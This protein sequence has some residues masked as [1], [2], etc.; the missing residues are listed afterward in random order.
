MQA[1]EKALEKKNSEAKEK[2]SLRDQDVRKMNDV[3][4]K[5]N[6]KL[7]EDVASLKELLK[8]QKSV[9]GGKLLNQKSLDTAA[10]YLMR[11]SGAKGNKAE[12]SG[13][14]NDVYSYIAGGEEV[15]WDGIMEKAS[16]AADWIQEH[17]D[18]KQQLDPYGAEVLRELRGSRVSLDESQ[19][20]EAEYQFGSVNALRKQLFGTVTITDK[21]AV[22][23]DSKWAELSRMYPDVFDPNTS[24]ADMPGAL[25]DAIDSLKNMGVGEMWYDKEAA[26]QELLQQIYHAFVLPMEDFY[27]VWNYNTGNTDTEQSRSVNATVQNAFGT[28]ATGYIDQLLKDLNGGA[29]IDPTTGLIS[30]SMNLFKKGA[31]FA[32]ASVVIQQPSAIGR[33][34]AMIDMKYFAGPRVTKENYKD[35]LNQMKKYAPVAVI[36]EMGYF[37]T[38]MGKSTKDYILSREYEGV[39]EKAKAFFTDS[40]YRDEALSRG[41]ALADEVTWCCIWEAVKR[42]TRAKHPELSVR[43]ETFLQMAGERFTD[44][45][46]KTQVY[47]SI[48]S[49]SGNM[50]SKD[51]GMKMATAFMAEPT[52]SINMIMDA[53][54]K[55]KRNGAQGRRYCRK[56]IGAVAAAQVINSVLVSFV[57]AARDDDEDE[58][59]LEKY[60]EALVGGLTDSV[61]PATYIPF[62]KDIMSIVQGYDVERSDLAVVSDLWKAWKQ[63]GSKTLSPWRKVEGFVGSLCQI[64]G[65]PVKNIMR[66]ARG[67]YQ[68][69]ESIV[70][71]EKNTLAGAGYAI[72]EGA[73]EKASVWEQMYDA[74]AAGDQEHLDRV[75]D[76]YIRN[77]DAP[78]ERQAEKKLQSGFKSY[79]KDQFIAGKLTPEE[80]KDALTGYLELD[81][82][83]AEEILTQWQ[84]VFDTGNTLNDEKD[85]YL[86]EEISGEEYVDYLVKYGGKS[87]EEAEAAEKK[88]RCERDEGFAYGDLREMYTEDKIT[89]EKALEC[90]QTYGGYSEEKAEQ[91]MD[92]LEFEKKYGFAYDNRKQ[93]YLDGEISGDELQRILVKEG[94]YTAEDAAAQVEVY[95]WEKQGVKGATK[96]QIATY[97]H[98]CKRAG[99]SIQNYM[100]V[101]RFK[102]KTH[103]DVDENGKGIP[104][105]AVRKVMAKIDSLPISDFQKEAIAHC[106]GWK[107]STIQTYR[108]W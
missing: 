91:Y 98:N 101:V 41:A 35:S 90:L 55:G 18:T 71:P 88:L 72:K 15:T 69:F 93:A 29:R 87:Q 77:S 96:E 45:I 21:D 78:N 104:Y 44:V 24:A 106:F 30:K 79:L 85:G 105:S 43:S 64:F 59:Y 86:R 58:T 102:G 8:L 51:T 47:D 100:E 11:S 54:V 67:C 57:Y 38:N 81:G 82:D 7:R 12:L 28:A 74:Y 42:E 60:L 25:L 95:E 10:G 52:T 36:K 75:E 14:L 66:D 19:R 2:F 39:G 31:V 27:R 50:R 16:K 34:L 62:L 103:N 84:G 37:D 61:N 5:Q 6:E 73:G 89:K 76:R 22:S 70:G 68:M 13:L 53:L 49:R 3:L 26:R 83:E 4:E 32:S 94:G 99:V 56:V 17:M 107:E 80:V 46:V 108:L 65:L 9:T 97:N 33:A 92:K 40:G 23:L 48:L 1:Y 20:A 63:L